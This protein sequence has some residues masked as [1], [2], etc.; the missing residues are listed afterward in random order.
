[1]RR[2]VVRPFV[3][4]LLLIVLLL[5]GTYLFLGSG[6]AHRSAVRLVIARMSDLLQRPIQVG[7]VDYD[8]Y[9]LAFELH[10]VVIPGPHPGDPPFAVIPMVR[11]QFSWRDLQQRVLRLEQVDVVRP[12]VYVRFDPDGGSNL[13]SLHTRAGAQSRFEV[14]I[15]H[16]LVEGGTFQLDETRMPFNLDARAVWGRMIGKADRKGEGGQR[17]D[18]QLTGQEVAMTLPQARRWPFTASIKGSFL[19]GRIRFAAARVAGPDLSSRGTGTVEWGEGK[20]RRIAVEAQGHGFA[21][22]VN[23][24]G[25]MEEPIRGPFDFDGRFELAGEKLTWSG[26]ARSPQIAVLGRTFGDIDAGFR[27][28]REEVD[29]DLHQAFYAG[30]STS[31]L[32]TVDLAEE[33]PK[34]GTPVDLDLSF[35][36]LDLR[37]LIVDQFGDDVAVAGELSGRTSGDLVYRFRTGN[38]VGGSGWVDAKVEGVQS[39]SGLPVAGSVPLRIENGVLSSDNVQ[40]TAPSQTVQASNFVFDMK[41]GAGHFDY[42]L[43]SKDVG[44]LRPVLAGR[45]APGEEPPLWLPSQGY[46]T[47]E[48]SV[49]IADG[50]FSVLVKLDLRDAVSPILSA[51]RVTGSLRASPRA[52]DDLRIEASNRDGALMLTGR[53][54]LAA[55][56]RKTASEPLALAVDAD[57]WPAAGVVTWLFPDLAG[58]GIDGRL[59]GRLDLAGTVGSSQDLNGRADFTVADA[60]VSGYALGTV[61]SVV[62]FDGSRIEVEHA[63]ADPPAGRILVVGGLDRKTDA[64]SFTVDAPSLSLAAEPFRS[65]LGGNVTGR[66]TLAAAIQGTTDRPGATVSLRGTDLALSGRPL[67]Q[68]GTAE[69]VASW[70][71][72]TVKAS[73]SLLGLATF[74]GGGPL[75]LKRADL[76]F[77]LHSHDLGTLARMASPRPLPDF[78]GSLD[79]TVGLAADFERKAFRAE[80]VLD[81][82]RAA[83]QGHEVANREPVVIDLTPERVDI[84]SLY[85]AEAQSDSEL[86]V[87]GTLGL[88]KE[89]PLDLRIQS[90]LSAVWAELALPGYQV[91][92]YLD[93]LATVRGTLQDPRVN[94]Q[95]VVRDARVIVPNFPHAFEDIEG[96][97]LFNRDSVEL[98]NFFTRV[99]GGTV[100][101]NGRIDLPSAGEG[102]SYR[103]QATAKDLSLR[104]P[105]GFLVRGDAD[106]TLAANRQ[107]RQITG[108]VQLSRA[109]YLEDVQTGVVQL[110]RG[111]LQRERVEVAQ[112][113][114]FLAGTQLNIR[115]NGPDALRVRNNVAD[116]HGDIDLQIQGSLATPVVFGQVEVTPGGKLVYQDNEYEIERGLLTFQ[117]PYRIDPI[118]D[119]VARTEV[120]NYEIS[121]SLSGTLDR[122]TPKF[123]S[124]E[125]LADLEVLALLAGGGSPDLTGEARPLAPGERTD[126]NLTNVGAQSFLANQAASLVSQRV[127]TLFGFDRFRIDPL[128]AESGSAVGGV[129]LT[130]GKR[131]S[132]NLFVTY[133]TNPSASEEYVLRIEW[134]VGDNVVLVFTRNGKDDTYAVDAE[135]EKRY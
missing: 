10:D 22:I 125:G 60:V 120:R 100:R 11:V 33:T 85:L 78:T 99:A 68:Q 62:T 24:W 128:Q 102:F 116:L 124:E 84:R 7:A 118:I 92:G 86:F 35:S 13:P 76:R 50:S 26:T 44:V 96:V 94:G 108:T 66:L 45:P 117:N 72:E 70:D 127:G 9:P 109:Y 51:D 82:L 75:T 37:S 38:P 101:A 69:A 15:G 61:R 49:T 107:A 17:I 65:A 114:E 27:G 130:V 87:A 4:A 57:R 77:A 106:L 113:D 83:Y 115:V 81:D 23:R 59:S 71:G 28:S 95:G 93:L 20:E 36:G 29:V 41:R 32:I 63:V 5:S 119:L 53:V 91:Q 98:G 103:V 52:V 55:E 30:G 88:G 111:A 126:S 79:G 40:L 73:G 6:Y 105:E 8:F 56:G 104:Y 2:W 131:I 90:T 122:L 74:D 14:Q 31:G 129:K 47:A 123:S 12:Q 54:P 34:P 19:P 25:Y 1:V 80:L 135:W 58:A 46:G 132:K 48:G 18:W 67:G 133:A 21:Q 97:V 112:T 16:I 89:T 121:L 39:R 134:Q 43:A 42:R 110:L 64:I 3:W